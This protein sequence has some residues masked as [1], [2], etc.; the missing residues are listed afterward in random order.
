MKLVCTTYYKKSEAQMVLKIVCLPTIW[1]FL[2]VLKGLKFKSTTQCQNNASALDGMAHA[3]LAV[4]S[5]Q[6]PVEKVSCF[7]HVITQTFTQ[8]SNSTKCLSGP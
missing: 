4:N 5:S 3:E 1:S 2:A 7:I 6:T 8:V